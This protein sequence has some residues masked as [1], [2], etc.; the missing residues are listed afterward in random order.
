MGLCASCLDPGFRAGR[1]SPEAATTMFS[2][3]HRRIAAA[4]ALVFISPALRGGV[5]A[6]Q[7]FDERLLAGHNRERAALGV[8]PLK[9]NEALARS[10]RDWARHLARTG[11]FEHSP[12]NPWWLEP[13]GENL[14]G[15]T[16]GYYQPESMI[17]L[18]AAEKRDYRPGVFPN[19]SRSGAVENVSHYT[20][21]VWARTGTVGCALKYRSQGRSS[22]LPL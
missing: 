11:R 20:Q 10:A 1:S 4:I 16:V 7:N 5:G 17:G 19:N 15:G 9:W 14:W 6:R 2:S 12:D 8:P 13:E 21:M 3:R 18:W 22:R